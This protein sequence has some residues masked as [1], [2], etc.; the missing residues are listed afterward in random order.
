MVLL[1]NSIIFSILLKF[2][3]DAKVP[4]CASTTRQCSM[5]KK[6]MSFP[7]KKSTPLHESALTE[8][9]SKQN[10][11][12]QK[13]FI[14]NCISFGSQELDSISSANS[15]FPFTICKISRAFFLSKPICDNCSAWSEKS[16]PPPAVEGRT[17]PV[18]APNSPN[19]APMLLLL[20]P[21]A[22]D[23]NDLWLSTP[24]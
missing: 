3:M 19:A 24:H 10:K 21:A 18:P 13:E 11:G 20:P 22:P 4:E 5:R 16:P 8:N 2:R 15:I 12:Q 14:Y 17:G 6:G 23:P 7:S 1:A 9:W